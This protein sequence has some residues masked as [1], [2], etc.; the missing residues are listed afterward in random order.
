MTDDTERR[1]GVIEKTLFDPESGLVPVTTIMRTEF[2][3]MWALLKW[4]IPTG[5]ALLALILASV[6]ANRVFP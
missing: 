5:I 4:G 1:L 3:A 2:T 6:N